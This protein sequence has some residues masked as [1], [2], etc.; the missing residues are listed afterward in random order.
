MTQIDVNKPEPGRTPLSTINFRRAVNSG[1]RDFEGEDLSQVEFDE[2]H[3]TG[4]ACAWSQIRLGQTLGQRESAIALRRRV[5]DVIHADPHLHD[6]SRYGRGIDGVIPEPSCGTPA[7]I[8]GWTMR[9]VD[10]GADYND[11]GLHG[12]EST[13]F[14]ALWVDGQPMP[15]FEGDADVDLVVAALRGSLF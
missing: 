1:R 6:Q 13:A 10:P 3:Y 8:A 4:I 7:C 9:F 14:R 2:L 15:S 11:F 12:L 5:F